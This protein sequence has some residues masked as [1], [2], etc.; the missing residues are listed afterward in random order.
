MNELA[1]AGIGFVVDRRVG[2]TFVGDDAGDGQ[3]IFAGEIQIAL[4]M[5]RAAENGAGAI[6]HQ[7]EIGDEH[8]QFDRRIERVNDRQA[9]VEALF[10]LPLDIGG[11]STAGAAFGDESGEARVGFGERRG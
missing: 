1:G 2:L 6:V 4:V 11:G 3:L 7:H 5:R 10:L 8:R 9:G